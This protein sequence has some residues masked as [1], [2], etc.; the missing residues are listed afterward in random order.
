MTASHN[1]TY[2]N[3]WKNES[4]LA[5]WVN[6]RCK[7]CQRFIG[8]MRKF[9]CEKCSREETL[10]KYNCSDKRHK[11]SRRYKDRCKEQGIRYW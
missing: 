3:N 11:T 2:T 7:K 5:T 9:Y 1:R 8:K 10:K 4:K 6:K